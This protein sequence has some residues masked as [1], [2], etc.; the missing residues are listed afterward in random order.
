M[1]R[2][3][4]VW[5][6]ASGDA[7]PDPLWRILYPLSFEETLRAETARN[8]LDPALVAALI[9]QESTFDPSAVSAA[10][11]RGLMQI[12][13]PTGR[14]LARGLRLRYRI[15][16]LHEPDRGIQ[17]GTRYLRRM[18]DGFGGRVDKA[19]AAYN[20]GPSRVGSWAR[21]RPGQTPEEF[22]E[23]IP[24]HETRSY[25]MTILANRE[26]YRRIYGL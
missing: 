23:G 21:A 26:H 22:I 9:W 4:P 19:L 24:F 18:V 11:A 6:G 5:V 10:G 12:M 2:A 25:V 8:G 15:D 13:P 16:M 17:M 1:R 7:L 14:E 3:Y 20:A